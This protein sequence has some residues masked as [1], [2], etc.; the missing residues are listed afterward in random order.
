LVCQG[1]LR[2]FFILFGKFRENKA[3]RT[4]EKC[5]ASGFTDGTFCKNITAADV[6]RLRE[7]RHI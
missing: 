6:F 4:A 7:E 2:K 1:F 5:K 3:N